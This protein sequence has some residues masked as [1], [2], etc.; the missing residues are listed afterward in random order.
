MDVNFISQLGNSVIVSQEL[1]ASILVSSLVRRRICPNFVE[2]YDTFRSDHIPTKQWSETEGNYREH[3]EWPKTVTEKPPKRNSCP[4]DYQFI[5][6]ELCDHGDLEDFIRK[7][8][9]GVLPLDV[10]PQLLFQMCFSLYSAREAYS[11][12]HYDVKLLN[13]FLRSLPDA[14][15]GHVVVRYGFGSRIF[16]LAPREGFRLC[17]KLADFG[18]TD[19]SPETLDQPIGVEQFTT[20]ENTPIEYLVNGGNEVQTFQADTFSLGLAMLH[21]F[22]GSGPYEEMM[23]EVMCPDELFDALTAVWDQRDKDGEPKE[24]P[25]RVVSDVIHSDDEPEEI[26]H[27]TLYR[28]L[29][30]CGIPEEVWT[31]YWGRSKSKAGNAVWNALAKLLAKR[32]MLETSK[33]KKVG[34]GPIL[35]V[36]T[37]NDS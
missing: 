15:Q 20:L 19:I 23:E 4:S 29:V 27:H 28:Y 30:L 25:Y 21:L 10:V 32:E 2:I 7:Q 24:G 35:D 34:I 12:R 5:R 1:H 33:N 14:V 18:T 31:T 11:M 9:N 22:T 3:R 36:R 13:F 17:V 8:P 37:S 16:R 26:L 6:M